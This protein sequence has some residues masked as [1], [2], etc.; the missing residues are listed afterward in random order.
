MEGKDFHAEISS[1]H[2]VT[3]VCSKI[4]KSAYLILFDIFELGQNKFDS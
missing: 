4:G 1:T 3:Q 2:L